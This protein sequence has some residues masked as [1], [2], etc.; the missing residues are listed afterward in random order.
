MPFNV[1]NDYYVNHKINAV[2]QKCFYQSTFLITGNFGIC[3]KYES[4]L[5]MK[6]DVIWTCIISIK[7]QN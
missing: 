5:K 1:Q 4:T 3:I 6:H 2:L 7:V